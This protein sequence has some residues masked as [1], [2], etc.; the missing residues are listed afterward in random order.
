[1]F[2]PEVVLK[3]YISLSVQVDL[4]RNKYFLMSW[5]G[6][7]YETIFLNAVKLALL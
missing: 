1:M 3:T 5:S 4:I 6:V 2:L 7:G